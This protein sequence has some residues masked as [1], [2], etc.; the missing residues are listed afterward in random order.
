MCVDQRKGA[1]AGEFEGENPHSRRIDKASKR[2]TRSVE[3][4]VGKTAFEDTVALRLHRGD[5][6][7]DQT[8]IASRILVERF[9]LI[10]HEVG[11]SPLKL[12]PPRQCAFNG[13][14]LTNTIEGALLAAPLH[15]CRECQRHRHR[16]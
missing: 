15:L 12:P 4:T 8:G 16:M 3:L 9:L 14:V 10:S 6:A 7:K 2:S 11:S 1:R 5:E 13:D